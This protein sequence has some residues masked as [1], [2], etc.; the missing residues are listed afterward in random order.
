MNERREDLS[1]ADL[2]TQQPTPDD[3]TL[4]VPR[5]PTS[6]AATN[7]PTSLDVRL[8]PPMTSRVARPSSRTG[9]RTL[10]PTA[11]RAS[12]LYG[13]TKTA[14]PRLP[15]TGNRLPRPSVRRR[16]RRL[17]GAAPPMPPLRWG[18]CWP[19][20]TPR[21]SGPAGPTSKTGFVDAHGKRSSR[22]TGWSPSSCSIWPGRSPMS[23]A[24]WRASGTGA[25]TFPPIASAPPSSAIGRSSNGSWQPDGRAATASRPAMTCW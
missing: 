9:G 14:P 10:E 18:R 8:C 5:R 13:T 21:A 6:S 15:R 20:R 17:I 23:A 25:T 1:T 12:G 22:P 11:N 16:P 24:G 7:V 19:P 3:L 2:A 4:T